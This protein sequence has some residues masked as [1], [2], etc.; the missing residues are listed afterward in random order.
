M[1]SAQSPADAPPPRPD[2][3][4]APERPLSRPYTMF[5]VS[6]AAG[7]IV[8]P[9]T[10]AA[11][12]VL[13]LPSRWSIAALVA[14]ALLAVVPIPS[15]HTHPVITRLFTDVTCAADSWFSLRVICNQDKFTHN[16]PHVIGAHPP[17]LVRQ[18]TVRPE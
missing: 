2:R 11:I 18:P 8:L 5:L 14:L 6:C 17:T 10:V 16:G 4:L 13:T 9:L 12:A 3:P 15:R 7:C 1:A